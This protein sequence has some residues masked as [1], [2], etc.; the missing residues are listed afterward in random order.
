[1]VARGGTQACPLVVIKS[2][3]LFFFN[4]LTVSV[5]EVSWSLGLAPQGRHNNYYS[6]SGIFSQHTKAILVL[7]GVWRIFCDF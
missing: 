6:Y 7:Q 3:H 2:P 5:G 4:E 1:M